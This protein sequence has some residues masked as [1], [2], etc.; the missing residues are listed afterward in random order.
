MFNAIGLMSSTNSLGGILSLPFFLPLLLRSFLSCL[1]LL[2]ALLLRIHRIGQTEVCH[3][4]NL[5]AEETREG[6][7]YRTLLE[8]IEQARRA[9]DAAVQGGDEPAPTVGRAAQ[10][11][12]GVAQAPYHVLAGGQGQSHAPVARLVVGAGEDQVTDA[13]EPHQGFP[14]G[15]H[16]VT[17]ADDLGQPAGDKRGAAVGAQTKAVGDAGSEA[18][19]VCTFAQYVIARGYGAVSP[20]APWNR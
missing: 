11:Q 6:D 4:W 9:A 8:K 5:I 20:T 14:P 17:E 19:V 2:L 10:G 12:T 7:V 15:A 3:L 16:G 1:L 13:G 18:L